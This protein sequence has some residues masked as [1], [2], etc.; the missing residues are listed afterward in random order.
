MPPGV[1]LPLVEA[2]FACILVPVI[3]VVADVPVQ[4]ANA[5]TANTSRTDAINHLLTIIENHVLFDP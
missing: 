3:W 5:A 1:V 2:V 4:P